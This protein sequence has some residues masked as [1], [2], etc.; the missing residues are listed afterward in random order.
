MRAINCS[1]WS[2][3]TSSVSTMPS[4]R[5]ST[6]PPHPFEQAGIDKSAAEWLAAKDIVA[7]GCDNAAV[8]V[9]PF[10][11]NDFLGV[12]KILLVDRGIYMLEFLD[13]G[14]MAADRCYEG[15][16]TVSPLKVTGA[17]GSPINPVVI[18]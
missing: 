11:G 9:I 1:N 3:V 6:E 10:D 14:A 13:F 12:H 5:F 4:S 8:E 2:S 17:T 15:F 7:V 18:G 16:M